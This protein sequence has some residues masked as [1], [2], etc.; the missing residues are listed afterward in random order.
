MRFFGITLKIPFFAHISE[1]IKILGKITFLEILKISKNIDISQKIT[2]RKISFLPIYPKI[3][4]FRCKGS[5]LEI[6]LKKSFIAHISKNIII[7]KKRKITLMRL[8]RRNRF[9][10]ITSKISKCQEKVYFWPIL[11]Y[12]H[13]EE[14]GFILRSLLYK[15]YMLIYKYSNI[16]TFREKGSFFRSLL[17]KFFFP[18]LQKYQHFEEKENH[19]DEITLKNRFLFISTKISKCQEKILFFTSF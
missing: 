6:T 4:T 8:L 1:N 19:F 9:L 11:K 3:S 10:F 13:I 15:Y 2:L 16:S 18:F 5:F 7:W 17:Y 12:H 14:N